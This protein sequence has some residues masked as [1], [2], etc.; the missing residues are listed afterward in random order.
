MQWK[1]W[2]KDSDIGLLVFY[3]GM[4]NERLG[5]AGT[6][7]GSRICGCFSKPRCDFSFTRGWQHLLD[8]RRHNVIVNKTHWGWWWWCWYWW[9]AHGGDD[10]DGAHGGDDDGGGGG[11]DGT[12]GADGDGGGGDDDDGTHGA[13][14]DGGGGDDGTH[15][16]DGGG[17]G[18]DDDDG[19]HGADG[20]GDDDGTHGADGDGGGLVM[21]SILTDIYQVQR[22]VGYCP[23]FD[24]L[25]DELTAREHLQLYSRLRGIPPRHQHRVI[26]TNS[27]SITLLFINTSNFT[28]N[29]FF[30]A[31]T[32]D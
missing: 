17:G 16:A 21:F 23:Q 32:G 25:Y 30:C 27:L 6:V 9:C 13:D 20:G 19:T 8:F 29:F 10:D 7:T 1:K 31:F 12:H 15:G 18:G 3:E 2:A 5:A 4:M 22:K 24:A 28:K 11:D 26:F 14:G